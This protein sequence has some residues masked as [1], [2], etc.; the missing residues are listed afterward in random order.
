MGSRI[1]A[2]VVTVVASILTA[3]ITL[4]LAREVLSR[5]AA[6]ARR[7][8]GKPLGEIAPDADRV[9]RRRQDGACIDLLIVGD[10]IA[11][12]LG[13]ERPKDVLGARIAKSVGRA[14]ARPVRLRTAAVVGSESADLVGQLDALPSDY[15]PD[16]AL[17][18]V[19]GN[20]VT[21]R[22]PVATSVEYLVDAVTR[23]RDRGAA[24]IVGT[25]PDLSALRPVPQPLRTLA[26]RM[27]H[28]LAAAQAEAAATAGAR[29]VS[30]RHAVGPMFLSEPDEMFSLDRFHPSAV[31]Y[32][33]T[34]SAFVPVVIDAVREIDE[35]RGKL[36]Q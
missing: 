32:R 20:D 36:L 16:V 12:G 11:A 26:G 19:G 34:A 15:S 10:S 21:H 24:V 3:A 29:V 8:I 28:R 35:R 31:G 4:A 25:C 5:Q 18:I 22:I 23:L 33:R 9:W 1:R 27:S 6:H 13:A 7:Q 2:F 30:L 14:L 17:V